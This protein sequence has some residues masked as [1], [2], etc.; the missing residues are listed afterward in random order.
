VAVHG[1][2]VQRNQQIDPIPHVGDFLRTGANGKK[3]VPATDDGLVGVVHVEVQAAAA[4]NLGENV[5]WGGNA[6]TGRAPYTNGEGLP[7]AAFSRPMLIGD[8]HTPRVLFL[9][10]RKVSV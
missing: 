5:T 4:E 8:K 10:A 9:A 7:H 3:C 6:L 1:V 2:L